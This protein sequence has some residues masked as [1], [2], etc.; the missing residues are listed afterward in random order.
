MFVRFGLKWSVVALSVF[1]FTQVSLAASDTPAMPEVAITFDDLPSHGPLPL[2]VTRADIAQGIVDALRRENAPP[3][4][5][6]VNAIGI[7]WDPSA[8]KA[9]QIWRDAGNLLGNHTLSHFDPNAISAE[10]FEDDVLADE[11]TLKTYMGDADW[12]WLRLPFLREGDTPEKRARISAFL[13]QHGYRIADVTIGFNDYDYNPPYVRCLAKNDQAGI[14]WL[15]VHYLKAAA[16]AIATSQAEANKVFG[17]DIKHVFL[18]H[19]GAFD[20]LMFPAVL[21]LLKARHFKLIT[22]PEAQSDPA[23]ATHADVKA[24][25]GG[26]LLQRAMAARNITMPPGPGNLSAQ[27]NA[28]CQ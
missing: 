7:K 9:L 5:G 20:A 13:E 25:W 19:I 11:P 18:L 1:G 24:E 26:S 10:A 27:I 15:K 8:A 21:D 2:G 6:F 16:D 12:H 3:I 14:E 22:L 4:Y 17:R 28:L 23:Y